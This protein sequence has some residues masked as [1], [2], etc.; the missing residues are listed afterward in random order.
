MKWLIW[1]NQHEAWWAPKSMGYVASI[2]DAGRYSQREA[3]KICL[4]A[5]LSQN[6]AAKPNETMVKE[7]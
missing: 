3:C 1:S 2:K 6:P 4:N 5:N 7:Y